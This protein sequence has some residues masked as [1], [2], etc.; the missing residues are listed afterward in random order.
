MD[1]SGWHPKSAALYA[2]WRTRLPEGAGLLPS[3]SH[4]DPA[5]VPLLLPN[6]YLLT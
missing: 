4:I 3:R 1:T 2:Y 6:I 5:D